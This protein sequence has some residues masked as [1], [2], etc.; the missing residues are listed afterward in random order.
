MSGSYEEAL[1]PHTVAGHIDEVV[2]LAE[3]LAVDHQVGAPPERMV[4]SV[5]GIREFVFRLIGH[6][7]HGM[8]ISNGKPQFPFGFQ[9]TQL[10]EKTQDF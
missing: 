5:V 9:P 10:T 7:E 3:M 2:R 6:F 4:T 1:P 8:R